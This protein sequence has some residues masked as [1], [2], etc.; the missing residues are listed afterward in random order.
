[1]TSV[2]A[3]ARVPHAHHDDRSFIRKYIFTTDHKIIGDRK[4]TRLNSSHSQISYAVF[5]LKKKRLRVAI[6]PAGRSCNNRSTNG[7]GL[8]VI[9]AGAATKHFRLRT[10]SRLVVR[11]PV[12]TRVSTRVSR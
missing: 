1:M 2:A 7:E 6:A 5:C 9:T 8:V 10:Q 4:S 3:T 11:D 12:A